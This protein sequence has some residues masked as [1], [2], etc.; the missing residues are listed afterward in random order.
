MVGSSEKTGLGVHQAGDKVLFGS[1][2]PEMVVRFHPPAP[3]YNLVK[4]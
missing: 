3:C 4:R 1:H 2:K